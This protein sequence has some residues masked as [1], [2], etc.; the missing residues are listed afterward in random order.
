MTWRRGRCAHQQN[1]AGPTQT[2]ADGQ[3]ADGEARRASIGAGRRSFGPF[4]PLL[5][6][7]G[8]RC[9]RIIP[10]LLKGAGLETQLLLACCVTAKTQ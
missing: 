2:A 4:F 9:G 7:Q 8:R 6:L 1:K 5:R 3:V 10:G